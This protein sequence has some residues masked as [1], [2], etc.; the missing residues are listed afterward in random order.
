[1]DGNQRNGISRRTCSLKTFVE[2]T[3]HE[4]TND[5]KQFK[6]NPLKLFNYDKRI[7]RQNFCPRNGYAISD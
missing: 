3:L 1:M 7:I 6:S 5:K 2:V 4:S